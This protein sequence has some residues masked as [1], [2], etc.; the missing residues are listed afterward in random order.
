MGQISPVYHVNRHGGAACEHCLGIVRHAS[1]CLTKNTEI[2]YA[3]DILVHPE[4]P[5]RA[6]RHH[7]SRPRHTLALR[8]PQKVSIIQI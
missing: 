5:D 6:R 2:F 8:T 4:K 1:W 3:Y 7:S